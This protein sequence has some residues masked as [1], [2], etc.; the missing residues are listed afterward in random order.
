[1]LPM[2]HV[3]LAQLVTACCLQTGKALTDSLFLYSLFQLISGLIRICFNFVFPVCSH[4]ACGG[5]T[6]DAGYGLW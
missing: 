5:F 6:F 3:Y 1:M 2:L 4:A